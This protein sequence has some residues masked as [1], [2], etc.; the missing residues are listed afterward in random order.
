MCRTE[1]CDQESHFFHH[2]L[3]QPLYQPSL[4]I[5]ISGAVPRICWLQGWCTISDTD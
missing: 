5:V 1:H 2:H 4:P 3:K